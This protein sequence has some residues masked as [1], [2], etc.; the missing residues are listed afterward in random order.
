[1]NNAPVAQAALLE[2]GH[3]LDLEA[4]ALRFAH[5]VEVP[6]SA[7]E[8]I[9][10][11]KPALDASGKLM[12]AEASRGTHAAAALTVALT[13][14]TFVATGGL[15]SAGV[16][17]AVGFIPGIVKAAKNALL[18]IGKEK[19]AARISLQSQMRG[20]TTATQRNR[21]SSKHIVGSKWTAVTPLQGWVHFHVITWVPSTQKV[22]LRSSCDRAI[23]FWVHKS[24]LQSPDQWLPGWK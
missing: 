17:A 6:F 8:A 16:A 15:G 12:I 10:G 5:I 23:Q 21:F 4:G 3:L 11:K 1:M 19:K 24:E 20:V 9:I 7:M 13:A 18:G 14:A 22:E 2:A